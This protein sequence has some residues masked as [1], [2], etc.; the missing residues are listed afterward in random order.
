MLLSLR[1]STEI[2]G[3]EAPLEFSRGICGAL[4]E[5]ETETQSLKTNV[6]TPSHS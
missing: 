6:K 1:V 2:K 4:E 3:T 5:G